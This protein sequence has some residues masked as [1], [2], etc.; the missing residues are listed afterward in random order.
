MIGYVRI[1]SDDEKIN[2]NSD[3]TQF[4]QNE[5]TESMAK[6]LAELNKE[7]QTIGSENKAY[8]AKFNFIT[9]S[10]IPYEYRGIKNKKT[11]KTFIA[12]DF[13]FKDDVTID[14]SEDHVTYRLF[15]K[16]KRIY[17]AQEK[18]KQSPPL[19]PAKIT[20]ATKSDAFPIPSPQIS[21]RDYIS[22]AYDSEGK[23][24][25]HSNISLRENGIDITS[26]ILCSITTPCKKRID[27][28]FNDKTGVVVEQLSISFYEAQSEVTGGPDISTKL[29]T[30][31]SKEGYS[32]SFNPHIAKLIGQINNLEHSENMEIISCSL[33]ALFEVSTDCIIKSAKHSNIII[34]SDLSQKVISVI[35]YIKD[36]RSHMTEISLSTKIDFNSLKNMLNPQKFQNSIEAAHLGAHKTTTYLTLKT[37]EDVAKDA[38]LFVVLTNEILTNTNIV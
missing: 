35:N 5:L 21:L 38:A 34:G 1:T 28:I 24:I 6:F 33:R 23:L 16:E 12:D 2:F 9:S 19:R 26:G 25:S 18:P 11:F 22:S 7:I 20:L 10:I 29:I 37:L 3:R 14:I 15:N 31:P 30:L 17:I 4:L 32:I 27:Y 8:L 13:K 36:H